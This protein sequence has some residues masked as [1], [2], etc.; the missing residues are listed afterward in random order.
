MD[1]FGD[2]QPTSKDGKAIIPLL[3]SMFESFQTKFEGMFVAF[4]SEI[5]ESLK[6][7]DLQMSRL[8][9]ENTDMKKRLAKLEERIEENE[10]YE[11]RDTLILSG[12][13]IPT[14]QNDENGIL[15][16]RTLIKD[17]LRVEVSDQDISVCHRLGGRSVSQRPDQ[18]DIIVKFCRRNT[19]IDVLSAARKM[20]AP[21][22]YVNEHLTPVSKT[23]AY[24]LRKARRKF[25]NRIAGTT[26]I[27]GKN[28]VWVKSLNLAD[29][30]ARET[31][32]ILKSHEKLISF[33]DDILQ[34]PITEFIDNWP[35]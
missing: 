24:V 14:Y 6:E 30:N 5:L 16:A 3:K 22:F 20:K 35:H 26:T 9:E 1:L 4:K 18:R 27:D 7:K 25:P 21:N 19:K 31:K 29:P 10:Q 8:K 11:R 12:T 32:V 15:V 34:C 23:I 2:F 28:C 13:S 17:K 33:C